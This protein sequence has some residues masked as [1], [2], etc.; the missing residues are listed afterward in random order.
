MATSVGGQT[1][2]IRIRPLNYFILTKFIAFEA[3]CI[4]Y[5]SL[6]GDSSAEVAP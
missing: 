2:G 5:L 6:P 1:L 3:A 4:R